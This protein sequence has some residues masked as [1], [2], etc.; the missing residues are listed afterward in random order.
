MTSGTCRF[1]ANWLGMHEKLSPDISV[2]THFFN[3]LVEMEIVYLGVYPDREGY[4]LRDD[5]IRAEPDA[6]PAR[7]RK[8][9]GAG[10]LH[11]VNFSKER[12]FI[13]TNPME[14]QGIVFRT[15]E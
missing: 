2:G 7:F 12:V 13:H 3:D 6:L 4:R 11:V 8:S 5:L 15:R 9:R 10:A 1:F 14:Q